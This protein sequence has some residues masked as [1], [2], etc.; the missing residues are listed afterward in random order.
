MC[1][2]LTLPSGL[3]MSPVSRTPTAAP[4]ISSSTWICGKAFE[5]GEG[6]RTNLTIVV[7]PKTRIE[8][9]ISSSAL[10][11]VSSTNRDGPVA[12]ILDLSK[13]EAI[14]SKLPDT[15]L[16]K[17]PAVRFARNFLIGRRE[18][19]VLRSLDGHLLGLLISAVV[20]HRGPVGTNGQRRPCQLL[21]LRTGVHNLATDDSQQRFKALNLL[22][23]NGEIIGRKHC[24]VSELS[25]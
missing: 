3:L 6:P 21:K 17:N 8:V 13:R 7:T 12:V 10:C 4:T 20:L 2:P 9:R 23:W 15:F 1:P 22:F 24:Q 11:R 16:A 25:R 5:M 19:D 18:R 14:A